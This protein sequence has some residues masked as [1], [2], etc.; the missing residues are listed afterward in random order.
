MGV[1][2]RIAK[3]KKKEKGLPYDCANYLRI[4]LFQMNLK[5]GLDFRDC[6]SISGTPGFSE[7]LKTESSFLFSAGS[8]FVQ[9]SVASSCHLA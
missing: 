6:H 4:D 5:I 9:L 3:E 8:F 2:L 7:C 1:F